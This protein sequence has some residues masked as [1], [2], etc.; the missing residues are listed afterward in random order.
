MRSDVDAPL[1]LRDSRLADVA[2]IE[3]IYAVEVLEGTASFELDPPGIAELSR[4]REA[5]LGHG[6]PYLVA[7]LGGRVAGY[8]YAGVYRPRPAYR[9]TVESSVYV[10]RWARRRRVASRLL[11]ALIA[12][13]ER[14]HA[15]QMIAIIGD[16]EHVASIDLHLGAGFRSVGTLEH[17]GFKFGRWIDSVLMQRALGDGACR[18]PAARA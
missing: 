14:T 6:L 1:T 7:E 16:S 2:H 10:A 18:P 8:A 15:R 13:C 12:A 3:A 17:V 5:V 4:R 11:E 9:Y